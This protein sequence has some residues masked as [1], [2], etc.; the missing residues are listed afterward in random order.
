M[1]LK[2]WAEKTGVK[3]LT[4][5]RWF[6]AGT[7]PVKTYQ[8]DS[9]TIIV[10]DPEFSELSMNSPQ[11][12]DVM[13]V[14]LKKTVEFS[15]N[16][17]SVEEFAA[18]VLSNFSLKFNSGTEG[19][20]YSRVRPKPEDIQE[21]FK[22]FLKPKG[23]KPK[24]NMFVADEDTLDNLVSESDSL[25]TKDLVDEIT[26]IGKGYSTS[27]S[28]D[29]STIPE[30]QDLYNDLSSVLANPYK[31]G[32]PNQVKTLDNLVAAEGIATRSVNSTPQLNYTDS[33]GSAFSNYS[34][35]SSA[36]TA[37][38][39]VSLDEPL[40][41]NSLFSNTAGEFKPTK[42]ELQSV[43]ALE[44]LSDKPKRGRKSHKVKL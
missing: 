23:E 12:N 24:P 13:S 14:F 6:K 2:E 21:H 32:P 25:A 4:A 27:L 26:R 43:D 34:P 15:K 33:T 41:V 5:Y 36:F 37:A 18:Y 40:Y 30:V 11:T 35:T 10:E 38:I 31:L 8:T 22:K 16:N 9:G 28:H 44:I 20:K 1:K 17:A 42:K 39:N 7:M 29:M 3:Y 19:P